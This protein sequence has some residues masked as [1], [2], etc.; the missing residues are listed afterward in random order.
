MRVVQQ[1]PKTVSTIKDIADSLTRADYV[2]RREFAPCDYVILNTLSSP[3]EA[4][5]PTLKNA[6]N[7]CRCA[8]R[9]MSREI[10]S[11]IGH[12]TKFQIARLKY[13]PVIKS[14]CHTPAPTAHHHVLPTLSHRS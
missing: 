13:V 9:R 10:H 14:P 1:C 6:P 2:Q 5:R 8:L 3:G 11:C 7:P 12:L 4:H